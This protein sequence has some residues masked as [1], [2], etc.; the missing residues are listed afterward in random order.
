[1]LGATLL[2]LTVTAHTHQPPPD[3]CSPVPRPAPPRRVPPATGKQ[4][5]FVTLLIDDLGFDDLR[6][7]DVGSNFTTFAPTVTTLLSDGLLLDRH[8]A[9]KWCS[10]SRR[11]FLTGRYPVSI[12]GKQAATASNLTPL[13]FTL[14]SEKLRAAGYE[15]HFVGKGP[16][17]I[18]Q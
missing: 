3:A 16:S 14:L 10:P 11:S 15:S 8:H 7:H 1:M 5:H 13:Q 6:S 2:A 4:P 18:N 17:P 12:T 9:Y